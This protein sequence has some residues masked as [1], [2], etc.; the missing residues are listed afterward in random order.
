[1]DNTDKITMPLEEYKYLVECE[2][3]LKMV[4]NYTGYDYGPVV[5]TAAG[6]FNELNGGG[7]DV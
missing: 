6:R 4:I 1:M 7:A 2:A 5:N 3:I